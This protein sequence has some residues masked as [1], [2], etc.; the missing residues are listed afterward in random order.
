MHTHTR[1][2]KGPQTASLSASLTCRQT[3]TCNCTPVIYHILSVVAGGVNIHPNSVPPASVAS[4]WQLSQRLPCRSKVSIIIAFFVI[5]YLSS[6]NKDSTP[7]ESPYFY[8]PLDPFPSLPSVF[9]V[10]QSG[11]NAPCPAA[12][13]S[14]LLLPSRHPTV[15]IIPPFPTHLPLCFPLLFP[16]LSKVRQTMLSPSTD[17]A[18]T[19]SCTC[20]SSIHLLTGCHVQQPSPR[21]C[22]AFLS[23]LTAARVKPL[24]FAQTGI[25]LEGKGRTCGH[26]LSPA[27]T[28]TLPPV[29]AT[30]R[31]GR[32]I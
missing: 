19:P 9:I 20:S 21:Q 15:N 16:K 23:P 2:H 17:I 10:L 22:L 4:S 11:A 25:Q 32:N 12:G 3:H 24:G 31:Q 6:W 14:D 1:T 18:S 13:L 28:H 7:S 29:P 27:L 30:S 26:D 5:Q 8:P